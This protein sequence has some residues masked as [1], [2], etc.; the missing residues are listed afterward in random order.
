MR[1]AERNIYCAPKKKAGWGKFKLCQ[2]ALIAA[3]IAGCTVYKISVNA[4]LLIPDKDKI[5]QGTSFFVLPAADSKSAALHVEVRSRIEELLKA[6]GYKLG[7]ADTAEGF[8]LFS[9]GTGEGNSASGLLPA[10]S[11]AVDAPDQTAAN[12][13]T[14]KQPGS[15]IRVEYPRLVRGRWF[16]TIVIDAPEYRRSGTPTPVWLGDANSFGADRDF[17]KVIWLLVEE[18]FKHFGQSKVPTVKARSVPGSN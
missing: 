9:F 14:E 11:P 1:S 6:D 5:P 3:V 17:D 15:T 18:T 10:G 16:I 2:A 13:Q 12:A 4:D 7:Q 8:L